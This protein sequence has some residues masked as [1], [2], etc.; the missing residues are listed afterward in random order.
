MDGSKRVTPSTPAARCCG[1]TNGEPAAPNRPEQHM[2]ETNMTITTKRI[3]KKAEQESE[4]GQALHMLRKYLKPGDTVHCVL[5]HVSASG[6]SRR[7][8]FYKLR[9]DDMIYLSGYISNLLGYKR[10]D[11]S[12]LRVDGCGMDMGFAVVY[13]LSRAL[14]P[15]GFKVS[16]KT[17]HRNGKPNG[18][19]DTDGG[20]ALRSTWI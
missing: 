12:G 17:I 9:G 14:Y 10:G 1:S 13:E 5:R 11:K 16:D 15:E 8:D 19:T 2:G 18:E 6:M 3:S 4:K 7:I 20:Y